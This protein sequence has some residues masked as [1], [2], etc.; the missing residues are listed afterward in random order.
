MDELQKLSPDRSCAVIRDLLPLYAEDMLSPEGKQAVIDHLAACETCREVYAHV[1]K[2][3]PILRRTE[4]E[5]AARPLKRFRWHVL[6]NILGAPIWLPL[7]LVGAAV[8]LIIYL[9]IWVVALAL[10]CIPLALGASA[11]ACLGGFALALM[12]GQPAAGV[13]LF[14]AAMICTGLAML[15]AFPCR[16]LCAAIVKLTAVLCRKLSGRRKKETVQ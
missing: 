7:L 1:S 8:V 5:Q 14:A 6:L 10:W 13:L 11:L 16:W 15:F 3:D 4:H 2:D 9:C 12:Q